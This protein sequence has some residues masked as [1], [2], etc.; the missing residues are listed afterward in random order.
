MKTKSDH[1]YKL[2]LPTA[3]T[4]SEI[5]IALQAIPS[6]LGRNLHDFFESKMQILYG[7]NWVVHLKPENANERLN[8]RDFALLQ[9]SWLFYNDSP[10]RTY[11]PS[12][13]PAFLE[14]SHRCLGHRNA[15]AHNDGDFKA[16]SMLHVVQDFKKFS[17]TVGL[18]I[19]GSLKDLEKRMSDLAQNKKWN[20]SETSM[21][22]EEAREI[23]EKEY[24][25]K[26]QIEAE[27]FQ[28]N[29]A[30]LQ[31]ENALKQKL[32][33]ANIE[34]QEGLNKE[35]AEARKSQE[36]LAL[37]IQEL[38]AQLAAMAII[39]SNP[40]SEGMSAENT[41]N[42]V[43]TW[44]PSI[45]N[46]ELID[47]SDGKYFSQ[48]HPN[49]HITVDSILE[50]GR[51][52]DR[53]SEDNKGGLI[54]RIRGKEVYIGAISK[55]HTLIFGQHKH[56]VLDAPIGVRL[57]SL[58]RKSANETFIGLVSGRK[59]SIRQLNNRFL[60]GD[61]FIATNQGCILGP[62]DGKWCCVGEYRVENGH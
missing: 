57:P 36:S 8:K 34:Q 6:V 23:F 20:K 54:S 32:L 33:E 17:E 45:A 52:V 31:K 53:V 25:E 4:Q 30:Q 37:Q 26:L 21:S 11:I 43:R 49:E 18:E 13:N 22:F 47:I 7:E 44:A 15:L 9:K 55:S 35:I 46:K 51:L 42:L 58:L 60:F 10:F 19:T 38:H 14:L 56:G 59:A 12:R 40:I 41:S 39:N 24:Q 48:Y 50:L 2:Y 5:S 27:I 1:D 28:M 3:D 61:R 29:L 62:V 16:N